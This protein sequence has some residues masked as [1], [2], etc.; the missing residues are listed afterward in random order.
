MADIDTSLIGKSREF[1]SREIF[2]FWN[3]EICKWDEGKRASIIPLMLTGIFLSLRE[4]LRTMQQGGLYWRITPFQISAA[5]DSVR[6]LDIESQGRV[7]D[8]AVW[9]DSGLGGPNPQLRISTGASGFRSG[10][11]IT[12]G[13]VN[14]LGKVP[15]GTQL[16]AASDF[17]ITVYVLERG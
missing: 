6:I 15:S 11:S 16:Y 17:D 4:L 10:I 13:T 3:E 9:V 5:G 7:R 12:P 1:L 8:V 2:P 14:E